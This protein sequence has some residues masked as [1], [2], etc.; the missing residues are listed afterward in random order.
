MVNDF[1]NTDPLQ[2][3]TEPVQASDITTVG[4]EGGPQL[5]QPPDPASSTAAMIEARDAGYEDDF[6]LYTKLTD[7]EIV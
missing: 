4:M 5:V 3:N 7:K 2:L 1:D 6:K